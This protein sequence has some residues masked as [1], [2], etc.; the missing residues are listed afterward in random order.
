MHACMHQSASIN[1]GLD[2]EWVIL[3]TKRLFKT[4]QKDEF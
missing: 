4:R 3:K 2:Q 1:L